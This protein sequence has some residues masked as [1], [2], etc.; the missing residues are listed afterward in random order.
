MCAPTTASARALSSLRIDGGGCHVNGTPVV[1][2]CPFLLT[3]DDGYAQGEVTTMPDFK[4]SVPRKPASFRRRFLRAVIIAACATLVVAAIICCY[5]VTVVLA[6]IS[7]GLDA[8]FGA[9][10]HGIGE[11]VFMFLMAP[12]LF[13]LVI[14]PW[15][16]EMASLLSTGQVIAFFIRLLQL[17]G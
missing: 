10:F 15:L 11:A 16:M 8:T 5:A 7:H 9:M 1:I 13:V 17:L 2:D 4:S 14:F 6:A 3:G 12:V